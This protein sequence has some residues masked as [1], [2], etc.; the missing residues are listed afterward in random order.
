MSRAE[1]VTG[2]LAFHGEGP[3]WDAAAGVLRWVDMLAGDLLGL[4]AAG[5]VTRTHVADVAAAWRPRR[6]GGGVLATERGFCLID[7]GS[8]AV[9][10][11][12]DIGGPLRPLP[13][14][15]TDSGIRMN[16]GGCDPQ[17]RFYCGTL[18]YDETPGA[19]TLYRLDADYSVHTVLKGVTISN[20][21]VW[22][23]D[24][25]TVYYAD[26]AT[27]G[28]DAFDFDGNDGAF[29]SRR[30]VIT[31]DERDGFP[32][33]ITLDEEGGLW[34]AIFRAGE[35][36]RY[37]PDRRLDA[38]ITVPAAQVT[39]CAFGGLK[40]DVLFITTSRNG[41]GESAEPDAGALFS[42]VP[43][44]RGMPVLSYSG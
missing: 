16:E 20:G 3:V 25:N 15:F 35:V 4:D 10:A 34:I 26:S 19:G 17:G 32:D 40:G 8:D 1:Q 39:A 14:V 37:T 38:V 22:S 9:G 23:A 12:A 7:A 11:G 42:F 18:A 41:L 33:G 13:E 28:V 6:E 30:R 2:P 5:N 44:V 43:G 36:R 27:Q 21:I 24:G 31:I 29:T